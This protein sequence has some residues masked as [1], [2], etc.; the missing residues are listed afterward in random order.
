MLALLAPGTTRRSRISN[1]I[2]VRKVYNVFRLIMMTLTGIYF[3]GLL[4]Q[5]FSTIRDDGDSRNHTGLHTFSSNY[6]DSADENSQLALLLYFS[7]TTLIKVGYGDYYPLSDFERF[8]TIILLFISMCFFSYL[9]DQLIVTIYVDQSPK[10]VLQVFDVLKERIGLK[11]WL[12]QLERYRDYSRLPPSFVKEL[13]QHFTYVNTDSTEL[14]RIL[15]QTEDYLDILPRNMNRAMT[16]GY[17]Y[18]DVLF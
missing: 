6:P 10:Q 13:D 5:Y 14:A 18:D 12:V 2:W 16:V 9:L 7:M 17:I 8:M 11:T 3:S 4:F 1:Q 15:V